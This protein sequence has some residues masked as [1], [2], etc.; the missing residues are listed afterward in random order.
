MEIDIYYLG[1][2]VKVHDRRAIIKYM[3]EL[4][5]FEKYS[6]VD[7]ILHD[8]CLPEYYL[9]ERQN[10]K[11]DGHVK[12]IDHTRKMLITKDRPIFLEQIR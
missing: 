1:S 11:L 8:F 6:S 7:K 5:P 3:K 10:Q 9:A 2:F 12:V 4:G